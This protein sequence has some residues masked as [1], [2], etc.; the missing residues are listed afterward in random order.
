MQQRSRSVKRTHADNR[1]YGILIAILVLLLAVSVFGMQKGFSSAL[2]LE[3]QVRC[4]MEEHLHT[5]E[6]YINHVLVCGQKAHTVRT[7]IC[8]CWRTMT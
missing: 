7:V 6:C 5:D 4:G 2:A 3:Q 1:I 8:F